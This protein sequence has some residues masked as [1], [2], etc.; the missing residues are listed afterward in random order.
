[1][2]CR[3]GDFVFRPSF[4]ARRRQQA[5]SKMVIT[6]VN[7]RCCHWAEAIPRHGQGVRENTGSTLSRKSGG[8]GSVV[9]L[10]IPA[11]TWPPLR[12]KARIK[13]TVLG[14][15]CEG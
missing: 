8:T 5:V 1:M 10:K 12:R 2:K 4:A 14:Q 3:V 15:W 13:A 6:P 11:R 9:V 7:R